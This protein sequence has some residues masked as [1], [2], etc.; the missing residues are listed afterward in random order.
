MKISP[1]IFH[2]A[3]SPRQNPRISLQGFHTQL[4]IKEAKPADLEASCMCSGRVPKPSAKASNRSGFGTH[5]L[6]LKWPIEGD[7]VANGGGLSWDRSAGYVHGVCRCV[8]LCLYNGRL[9]SFI[10]CGC[11]YLGLFMDVYFGYVVCIYLGFIYGCLFWL[12][13]A[14]FI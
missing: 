14:I 2:L 7:R 8:C 1:R 10:K 13:V 5:D 3:D 9:V 4:Q 12:C 6:C 11:I